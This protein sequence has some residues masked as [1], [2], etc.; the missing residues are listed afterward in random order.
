MSKLR[1]AAVGLVL[2]LGVVGYQWRD[3]N[4]YPSTPDCVLPIDSGTG[5]S[6]ALPQSPGFFI[7]GNDLGMLRPCGCSKPVLGGI[8]RRGAFFDALDQSVRAS[9]VVVSVGNL[10]KEGGRQQE[11]K[12]EAFLDSFKNMGTQVFFPGDKDLLVGV[13][14]WQDILASRPKD[15]FP[16]VSAN[17]YYRGSRLFQD[18]AIVS[19]GGE[20]V[21]M[22]SFV[23]PSQNV[24]SEP[25][26]LAHEQ[27][28]V[29]AVIEALA[30][31]EDHPRRSLFVAGTGT[32]GELKELLGRLG[33]VKVA[34]KTMIALAG[35]SDI[36][37]AELKETNL[38][39]IETGQKG[40][41]VAYTSWPQSQSLE[42]YTLSADFGVDQEQEEI[43]DFYRDNVKF[44]QLLLQT[45]RFEEAEGLYAGSESCGSCHVT[46]HE[47]WKKSGHA[48]AFDVLV[49]TKDDWDPEC[50][51]CHVVDS[52]RLGGFDPATRELVHVQ[53]EACHGPSQDHVDDQ[54]PTPRGKLTRTFCF[55]CHDLANSPKFTFDEYWPK[56]A[57]G[58]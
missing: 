46:A 21:V 57:H 45:P 32:L 25:D 18:F 24:L 55:K 31:R 14:F 48:R 10:I 19:V 50:V 36:P 44:E 28:D 17:L 49:K 20:E 13:S 33:L 22:T 3:C 1:W 53:C 12:V 58:K 43:L 37:I 42:Y 38:F 5:V 39:G 47:T 34:K 15:T 54:T 16:L 30:A 27:P 51:R 26:L 29:S 41:D 9:S 8:A 7:I 52:D 35:F 4:D 6:S 40:R 2:A 11:L 23:S 56:I